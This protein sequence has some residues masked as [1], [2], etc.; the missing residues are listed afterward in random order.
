MKFLEDLERKQ[1][2]E[3]EKLHQDQLE[4]PSSSGE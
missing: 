4:A 2:A 3:L 1:K